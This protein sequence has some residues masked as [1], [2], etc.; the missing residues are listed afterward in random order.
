VLTPD[1]RTLFEKAYFEPKT[2]SELAAEY[3]VGYSAIA[4]RLHRIK[5]K[6]EGELKQ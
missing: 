3:H 6:L 2:I 4:V 1:E 5:K